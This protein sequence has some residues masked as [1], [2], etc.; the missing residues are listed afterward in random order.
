MANLGRGILYW[1]LGTIVST[2]VVGLV[3]AAARLPLEAAVI[4]VCAVSMVPLLA[5]RRYPAVGGVAA[6]SI[7]AALPLAFALAMRVADVELIVSHWRCGTGDIAIVFFTPFVQA[8]MVLPALAVWAAR[9]KLARVW[10]HASRIAVAGV[11]LLALVGVAR[12]VSRGPA[13]ARVFDALPHTTLPAQ[14]ERVEVDG[15]IVQ[16]TC[17]ANLAECPLSISVP[18]ESDPPTSR[19]WW[20]PDTRVTVTTLGDLRIVGHVA[21]KPSA[22]PVYGLAYDI[23]TGRTVDVTASDLAHRFGPAYGAL[24]FV[25][26]GL[27]AVVGSMAVPAT[28]VSI[29][30]RLGAR[31]PSGDDRCDES[32]ALHI[33]HLSVALAVGLPLLAAASVGLLG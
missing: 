33:A 26:L 7:L 4:A 6:R 21:D 32:I 19:G 16:R 9:R 3:A 31:E 24:V 10:R 2:A 28:A 14:F 25:V 17:E 13:T 8:L 15:L 5:A 30:R 12:S 18:G 23:S 22:T 20:S 1:F 11:M 27:I 29:W